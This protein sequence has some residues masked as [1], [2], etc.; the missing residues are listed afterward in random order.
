MH[1]SRWSSILPV[2]IALTA[3]SDSLDPRAVPGAYSLHDINGRPLPTYEA[4]TPGL[5]RT[6]NSAGLSIDFGDAAE[7]IQDVTQFDGTHVTIT[8]NYTY[9][10]TDQDLIFELSPSCPPNANCLAAPKG[11]IT[12][13]GDIDLDIGSAEFPIVYHFQ[14][15]T[16]AF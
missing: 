2:V 10:I 14:R 12:S 11:R 1:L 7:L 5:T 13:T 16:V 8:T 9:R 4:P 6:I 15:I 3:C